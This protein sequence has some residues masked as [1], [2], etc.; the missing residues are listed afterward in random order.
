MHHSARG[1]WDQ[2]FCLKSLEFLSPLVA[3][4]GEQFDTVLDWRDS[5]EGGIGV[6]EPSEPSG[7]EPSESHQGQVSWDDPPH[8]GG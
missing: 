3:E 6:T 4:A 2:A 1:H 8:T 5:S 7:S